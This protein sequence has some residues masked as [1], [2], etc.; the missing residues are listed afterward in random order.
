[1][2]E[3]EDPSLQRLMQKT[4]SLCSFQ[5]RRRC[6]LP[7]AASHSIPCHSANQVFSHADQYSWTCQHA[8]QQREEVVCKLHSL[9]PSGWN[10][11]SCMNWRDYLLALSGRKRLKRQFALAFAGIDAVLTPT[12][13]TPAISVA[14]IDQSSTPAQF[15]RMVNLLD[16]CALSLPNG[17]TAAGLPISLQIIGKAHDEALAL[18][19]GWAYEQATDWVERI[20]SGM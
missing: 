2:I 6:G 12:T 14:E 5:A 17:F 16:L 4:D 13:A 19:I 10:S 11:V 9:C 18:R 3:N 7:D 15:T 20:P 1:M 8:R